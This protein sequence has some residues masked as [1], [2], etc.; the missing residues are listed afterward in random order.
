VRP[1]RPAGCA[2]LLLAL[3]ACGDR[4]DQAQPP[5]ESPVS[6]RETTGAVEQRL[7]DAA[8]EGASD[9]MLAALEAGA[10][11]DAQ[12]R[13]GRTALMLAAFNG[14]TAAVASLLERGAEPGQRDGAGRNALM[15][16]SSGPYAEA[17]ELLLRHGADPNLRD[18]AEGWTALM[19]AAGEGQVD[20]IRALLRHG[21][22]VTAKNFDGDAAIDHARRRGHAAAVEQL[23]GPG[24]P[25]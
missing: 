2:L 19:F 7:R 6:S 25:R 1:G 20:V 21:A 24:A 4:A 13:E 18:S 17:V 9:R 10:R 16:A 15:Y 3:C 22:D 23:G 14:Q 5:G 12:D 11:V 8:F